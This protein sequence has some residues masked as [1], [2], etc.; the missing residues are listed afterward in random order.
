MGKNL[1][2]RCEF[3]IFNRPFPAYFVFSI[4]LTM[5]LQM[6]NIKISLWL[7]SNSWSW[8]SEAN[9]L[10]TEPQP[11]P[12]DI[13]EL[14]ISWP[15]QFHISNSTLHQRC[16]YYWFYHSWKCGVLEFFLQICNFIELRNLCSFLHPKNCR[17]LFMSR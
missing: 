3:N 9:A 8:V 13:S 10:P 16:H 11:L 15:I 5:G 6:F 17:F 12:I 2:L 1:Q 14:K 4:Q 7:D